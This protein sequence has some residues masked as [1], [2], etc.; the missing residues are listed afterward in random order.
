MGAKLF[1]VLNI[2]V[3]CSMLLGLGSP[4]V[5]AAGID[6]AR[7]TADAAKAVRLGTAQPID[8]LESNDHWFQSASLGALDRLTPRLDHPGLS[9]GD[10]ALK[11]DQVDWYSFQLREK[12]AVDIDAFFSRSNADVQMELRTW[13]GRRIVQAE[14]RTDGSFIRTQ[15]LAPGRYLLRLWVENGRATD[16]NL[17]LSLPDIIDSKPAISTQQRPAQGCPDAYEPN[18]AFEQSALMGRNTNIDATL[19][20]QGDED[21]FAVE[22]ASAETI[23]L[24][25]YN[26]L[27]DYDLALF[28]ADNTILAES[29][30]GGTANEHIEYLVSSTG[31][32]Y[33]RVLGFSGAWS[34]AGYTLSNE[35][36]AAPTNTPT[37][38]PT[39]TSCPNDW[40]EPN[41]SFETAAL[42]APGSNYL[43]LY[44]CPNGDE[45]WFQFSVNVG[46]TIDLSLNTLPADY[47]LYLY[48]PNGAQVA[49][50]NNGGQADE[51]IQYLAL[52]SG[53]YRARVV[54]YNG[55]FSTQEYGLWI[56]ILNPT[57]TWTPTAT[58]SATLTPTPTDT[59]TPTSTPTPT[60]TPTEPA[61]PGDYA[62]NDFNSANDIYTGNLY[63]AYLCPAGDEDWFKFPAIMGQQITV[64][65]L[66]PP[67]DYGFQL[68]SPSQQLLVDVPSA[69]GG[70]NIFWTA[71]MAGE[72]RARVYSPSGVYSSRAYNLKLLLS[73]TPTPT[74]TPS[75]TPTTFPTSTIT[76]TATPTISC[77]SD[78]FEYNDTFDRATYMT[79]LSL[80]SLYPPGSDEDWYQF[81][82]VKGEKWQIKLSALPADFDLELYD[83]AQQRLTG[84][85]N[86][87]TQDEKIN[88]TATKTGRYRLRVYSVS[89]QFHG[90]SY[91]LSIERPEQVRPYLFSGSA[92]TQPFDIDVRGPV[93]YWSELP[94]SDSGAPGG[95]YSNQWGGNVYKPITV[96]TDPYFSPADLVYEYGHI[97]FWDWLGF[98]R[99]VLAKENAGVPSDMASGN[100]AGARG[101]EA[102]R[103]YVYWGDASALNRQEISSKKIS[104][105][106]T[107]GGG[108]GPVDAMTADGGYIYWTDTTTQNQQSYG[109]VHR[110]SKSG[111]S[112]LARTNTLPGSFEYIAVANDITSRAQNV[113]AASEHHI[114][115]WNKAG[116]TPLQVLYATPP[117]ASISGLTADGNYIY[118]LEIDGA[119][120]ALMY[121]PHSGGM[122]LIVT[123][124]LGNPRALVDNS[125]ELFWSETNGVMA[126]AK[127]GATQ[128]SAPRVSIMHAPLNPAASA[129]I[130]LSAT[131][132]DDNGVQ[133][134]EIFVNGA[135]VRSC[136]TDTCSYTFTA[137]NHGVIIDYRAIATD[138][139]GIRAS[140]PIKRIL[141]DNLGSDQD[142]DMLSDLWESIL[143]TNPQ[144]PDSD[145]DEILDGWELLGQ[146][147]SDGTVLDLP[148]MGAHPCRPDVFVEVDWNPGTP[149]HPAAIQQTINE[150][151]RHGIAVHVD[152]GQMGGGSQIPYPNF[153]DAT[154]SRDDNSSPYR[155]WAFHYALSTEYCPDNKK[156]CGSYADS[157]SNI[158]IRRNFTNIGFAYNFMHELGHSIGL[159]HGGAKGRGKQHRAKNY[160]WYE[161]GWLNTHYKPNYF[162]IMNYAQSPPM[163]WNGSN[164][165]RQ[166]AYSELALPDLDENRLDERS[167]SSFAQALATYPRAGLPGQPLIVYYCKQHDP[168]YRVYTTGNQT[169]MRYNYKTKINEHGPFPSG[170]D[171][172]CNGKIESSVKA[173]INDDGK[174]TTLRG[175][176]DWPYLPLKS[177]C[178]NPRNS[179]STSWLQKAD[180]PPCV[181]SLSAL[182]TL[183]PHQGEEP[184]ED[185]LPE[186]D[187]A[188]TPYE[189]C[190]G[191]D[192]DGD[193]VIDN[194]CP[195]SD[196]DSISDAIDNC[197]YVAN[198]EQGDA[199]RNGV[200]DACEAPPS[201]PQNLAVSNEA[202]GVVLSWDAASAPDIIGY[203]IERL[204]PE[205]SELMLQFGP[206]PTVPGDAS[207]YFDRSPQQPGS[208][209]YQLRTVNWAGHESEPATISVEVTELVAPEIFWPWIGR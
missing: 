201:P 45:D 92:R 48:D 131:A 163:F 166:V 93:P 98:V 114:V 187:L 15:T 165:V 184:H 16:Y 86:P 155:A 143:C 138:I 116:S 4:I 30:N 154:Q 29:D 120:N 43:S 33:I 63:T 69:A 110:T 67:A 6:R 195:D 173:D 23:Y 203:V 44:I 3:I 51:P 156:S 121:M 137:P 2:L 71:Y 144:N 164:I 81:Q 24:D 36:G 22:L 198:G 169:I 100:L 206:Y 158:T 161:G 49:Q 178:L 103:R 113:Y 189:F 129:S 18:D 133:G 96:Y 199:D 102:D 87:G 139:H 68:Y 209:V 74:V 167:N 82:V 151:R 12:T 193:G 149:S 84:S 57:A 196:E 62:G 27:A 20:P 21:W 56:D 179:Y 140:T 52:L 107:F 75:P 55:A 77:P 94:D 95:I 152:T 42:L 19:C 72:Y 112:T 46:Q 125:T 66:N 109:R 145:G 153:K 142:Q 65:L 104:S 146:P 168:P 162:S 176:S 38:S 17:H 130:T 76:P 26:L 122:P 50:S 159:G 118:W 147:F 54:G 126:I 91:S 85:I 13:W 207:R 134:I 160:I 58:P 53:N 174:Y 1:R 5:E 150:Y 37:P 186:D 90:Y 9:L 170:V 148:G 177:K 141:V 136:Q 101:I 124:G 31:T 11:R 200:G 194:D 157:G 35:I 61:C 208:Y 79:H 88:F 80:G 40:K 171:W 132:K 185:P 73:A 190:N 25:L 10:T 127:P 188:S 128:G 89:S 59:P 115:V 99:V 183:T 192:S 14:P 117:G 28:G 70:Y 205:T 202:G 64:Q 47:D 97:Y 32:Y 83:P 60:I 8:T 111:G 108:A 105:L 204:D 197:P 135:S 78:P 172:N 175:R 182:D 39:P 7:A 191:E 123:T 34:E 106:V 181:T 119:G 41:D 180:N